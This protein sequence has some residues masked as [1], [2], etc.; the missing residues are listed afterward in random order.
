[1][2]FKTFIRLLAQPQSIQFLRDLISETGMKQLPLL[3]Q[4]A[5]T[6]QIPVSAEIC[7]N[8]KHQRI[9]RFECPA[10]TVSSRFPLS[11]IRIKNFLPG[12]KRQITHDIQQ[13]LEWQS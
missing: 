13:L 2:P 7:L 9:T 5:M 11:G 8:I 1:R 12:L 3:S 4:H 6:L 10:R